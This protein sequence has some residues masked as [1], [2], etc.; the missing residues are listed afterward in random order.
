MFQRLRLKL[1][2]I[3]VTIILSLF[4]VLICGTYFFAKMDFTKRTQS[5]AEHLIADIQSERLTDLPPRPDDFTKLS[6]DVPASRQPDKPPSDK[7][8]LMPPGP[9][10][11]FKFFFVKASPDGTI[12]FQSSNQPLAASRLTTLT[13]LALQTSSSQDILTLEGT[14]YYY[15]KAPLTN[16]SGIVI[17][18]HDIDPETSML[19]LVLTTLLAVGLG[20]AFLSFGASFYMAN[21][22]MVP[23]KKAW[24]QQRDFLSDA[25]HELR[26]PLTVIQTN[27]DIVLDSMEETVASQRKWLDNIQEES[28]CMKNLVNSLLFL[29]RADS[30]QQRQNK[31]LVSLSLLLRQAAAPFEAIARQQAL[32]LEIAADTAI[33]FCGDES[34]LKQ[35]IAIL[36]DN[37]CRHTDPGG[38]ITAALSL[39]SSKIQLTVSD[40]GEGIA[41]EH[42]DKIFDRFYQVDK[43]RNQGGSGLGLAIAKWIVESHHGTIAVTSTPGTGTTFTIQFPLK[44]TG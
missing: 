25:S 9:P 24:Q 18:F 22:A 20:C 38:K 3:N 34:Q 43:S 8:P 4:F 14:S 29:A 19:Q 39:T 42:L 6:K 11:F 10:G 28:I 41:P 2:L 35:V 37:A 40:T 7:P 16:P 21:R 23:I 31:Q 30:K 26:T 1:T 12:T 44:T 33:E 17:V 27:L 36:L 15:Q 5:I 13:N 32:T